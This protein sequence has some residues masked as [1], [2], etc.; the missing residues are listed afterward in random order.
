MFAFTIRRP[1][2]RLERRRFVPYTVAQ[3]GPQEWTATDPRDG[4]VIGRNYISEAELREQCGTHTEP[5]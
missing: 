1:D 5:A 2:G 3:T 4:R